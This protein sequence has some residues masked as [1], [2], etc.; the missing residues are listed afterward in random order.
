MCQRVRDDASGPTNVEERTTAAPSQIGRK[1]VATLTRVLALLL[2][3][4][5]RV[6]HSAVIR[7]D[8]RAVRLGIKACVRRLCHDRIKKYEATETAAH[9]RGLIAIAIQVREHGKR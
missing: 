6:N 1:Q 5:A 4:A 2:L 3:N 8:K 9:C 7:A